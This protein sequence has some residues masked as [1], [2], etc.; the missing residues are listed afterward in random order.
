MSGTVEDLGGRTEWEDALMKH[1]II[2]KKE[3]QPTEDDLALEKIEA[4]QQDDAL[5]KLSLKQL[6]K[7]EDEVEEDTL[8]LYRQRRIAELKEKAAK[9]KYG[10]LI[11]ISERDYKKE[12]TEAGDVYCVLH[13]YVH[14][15]PDCRLLNNCLSALARKFRAVKFMGIIGQECIHNYPDKNCPTVLIYHK[16]ELLHQFMH[17]DAYGGQKACPDSVE[18]ALA[19]IG[20]LKT[21]LESNPLANQRM[22][23][24]RNNKV[25]GKKHESESD[26]SDENSEDDTGRPRTFRR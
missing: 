22:N 24:N 15:K 7:L 14:G 11:Q 1:G 2:P 13:L 9:E 12:V 5:D 4:S 6:S 10:E 23:I 26:E 3:I 16:G 18:W 17:L 25:V 8:E 19:Q 20:V 21:D